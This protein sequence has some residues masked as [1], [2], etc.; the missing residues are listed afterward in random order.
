M[1]TQVKINFEH[2]IYIS[3]Q[4]HYQLVQT[5]QFFEFKIVNKIGVL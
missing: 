4:F 5:A 3:K 1:K 2:L